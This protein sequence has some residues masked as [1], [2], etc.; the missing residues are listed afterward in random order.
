MR[1]VIRVRVLNRAIDA[2]RIWHTSEMVGMLFSMVG[3]MDGWGEVKGR[4]LSCAN[5]TA[6]EGPPVGNAAAASE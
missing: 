4:S 2:N 5:K 1:I 6:F 3:E